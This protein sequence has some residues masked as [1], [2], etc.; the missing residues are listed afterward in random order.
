MRRT[1]VTFAATVLVPL[2]GCSKAKNPA[3]SGPLT[4]AS[5][6]PSTSV[7]DACSLLTSDEIKNIQGEP[8]QEAKLTMPGDG[9]LQIS[10]CFFGLPS[11]A[12]SISLQ[13]V[14]KGSG[15]RTARD[16]W[17][18]T[19]AREA[20]EKGV[21]GPGEKERPPEAI[22]DLGDEAYW[23]AGRITALHVLSGEHYIQVSVGGADDGPTKL[24]K[25][26]T[27]AR[28]VLSRLSNGD[29]PAVSR[30]ALGR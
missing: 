2:A 1:L 6:A 19:F 14:G 20:D 4:A 24:E 17:R 8:L 26:K 11:F 18:E 13:V 7:V 10:Q 25:S 21:A 3:P 15:P 12:K 5:P 30:F 28:L 9:T 22:P 23:S 29:K 27:I 16:Q